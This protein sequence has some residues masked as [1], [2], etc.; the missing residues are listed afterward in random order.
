MRGS[1][2]IIQS[3][4]RVSPHNPETPEV[5]IIIINHNRSHL[6]DKCLNSIF[7]NTAGRRYEVVLV[8]NG[9]EPKEFRKV[10]ELPYCF[11]LIRIPVNR[12]FSE[13]NNIGVE[14]SRG[15]FIVLLNN[16]T[17]VSE[18][19]LEPLIDVLE[20][21]YAAG[22]VGPR[23]LYPNGRLQEAGA[24]VNVNGMSIRRG[25]YY[26]MENEELA[27]NGVVDYCS[28]ACFATTRA[29][30]NQVSGFDATYEPAYYEDVDLCMKIASL[31]KFIY[32]CADSIVYHV[33]HGTT[34]ELSVPWDSLIDINRRKFLS[35]WSNY[36]S[37]REFDYAARPQPLTPICSRAQHGPSS[38][39]PVA[40]FYT[41]YD[42]VPGG[43]ERY[44]L[45]A[46]SALRDTHRVYIATDAR[47]SQFRLDY[48]ARELSLDLSGMSTILRSD[49]AV[50]GPIDVYCHLCNYLFPESPPMGQRNFLI[51]QFLFSLDD[52]EYSK[53]S[54]N[55]K[56]YERII[57]YSKFAYNAL[58]RK[59]DASC[60]G[61]MTEIVAP[62]LQA[63]LS[64]AGK[65]GKA[66]DKLA[67][68]NVG[69]FSKGRHN[70]R[71]DVLIEALARLIAQGI[72]A[73]L[74]LVGTLHS[75]AQH[76]SH[77]GTLR[78]IAD[79]LPVHFHINASHSVLTELLSCSAIYWHATGFGVDAQTY[80]EQCEHFGISILE[81]MGSGCVPIVVANGGPIEFVREN[82]TGFHYTKINE[83][84][85]T[86]CKLLRD[87]EKLAT[88]SK[89]SA[90]E[91]HQFSEA[92]FKRKWREIVLG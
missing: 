31:G 44:L 3:S 57:V 18:G 30:F 28:A 86:T 38:G 61:V 63:N 89:T 11:E 64:I 22:G 84:V 92:S 33:E 5:S 83:L 75:Q 85:A 52:E 49:L 46:A 51:C 50:L 72:S 37:A 79:D 20:T 48:M 56:G 80:P 41:P 7:T 58:I 68:V 2:F 26:V 25:K 74:H 34:A 4:A 10:S 77:F 45:T 6:T 91:V 1:E 54:N 27:N 13:A 17:L 76:V 9:S 71:Q 70:K 8:D 15:Q 32:Y 24:F 55:L 16:D 43:G 81:A 19:W 78:H 69:R 42:L 29:I 40:V 67:I 90:K 14:T 88:I 66:A 12:Y 53:R 87:R 35:R 47:Y 23:L 39:A 60:F 59:L 21:S 36:L 65:A 82:E 62:P 73:E